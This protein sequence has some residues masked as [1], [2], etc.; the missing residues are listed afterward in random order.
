MTCPQ[1]TPV[2]SKPAGMTFHTCNILFTLT[3]TKRFIGTGA[4]DMLQQRLCLCATA[5]SIDRSFNAT[6]W[7]RMVVTVSYKI[8]LLYL[9]AAAVHPQQKHACFM[10]GV[11]ALFP[12]C[13]D[14]ECVRSSRSAAAH[15]YL[16]S[17]SLCQ[18]I[19]K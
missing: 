16:T 17:D 15:A 5:L 8:T 6:Q 9:R 7:G 10:C 2:T 1:F 4:N 19:V 14:R 18:A 13:A 3:G 11:P 12:L